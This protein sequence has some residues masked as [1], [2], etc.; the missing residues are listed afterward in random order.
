MHNAGFSICSLAA[1]SRTMEFYL[2][3]P[4]P[5]PSLIRTFPSPQSTTSV[6]QTCVFGNS[7]KVIFIITAKNKGKIRVFESLKF[8]VPRNRLLEIQKWEVDLAIKNSLIIL[9]IL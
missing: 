9:G 1:E 4:R 6:L 2:F 8:R 7:C 3:G 5:L